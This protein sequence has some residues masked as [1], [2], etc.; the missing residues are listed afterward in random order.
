VCCASGFG[1]GFIPSQWA[2]ILRHLLNGDRAV[3]GVLSV[4]Q[5]TGFLVRSRRGVT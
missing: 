1:V 5:G 3:M 4:G 2:G